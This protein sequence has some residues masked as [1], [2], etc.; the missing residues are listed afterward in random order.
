MGKENYVEPT[1]QEQ[2][3]LARKSKEAER[4]KTH[5]LMKT[6]QHSP[7]D[8]SKDVRKNNEKRMEKDT[9]AVARISQE[10][11]KHNMYR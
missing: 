8:I 7:L 1:F 3:F 11:N 6:V 4:T 2:A 9:K 5:R 10:V